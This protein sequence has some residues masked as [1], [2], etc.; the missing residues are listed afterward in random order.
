[1]VTTENWRQEILGHID[2]D[3]LPIYYGGVLVDENGDE[4]C[5]QLIPFPVPYSKPKPALEFAHSMETITIPAGM[6]F[7]LEIILF[8]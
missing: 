1:M 2:A 8:A 5:R 6:V 3:Y 4:R 7:S